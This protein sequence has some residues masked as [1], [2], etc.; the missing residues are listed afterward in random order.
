MDFEVYEDKT[1]EQNSSDYVINH[2]DYTSKLCLHLICHLCP[3]HREYIDVP[4]RTY[5]LVTQPIF[6]SQFFL[7]I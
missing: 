1:I 7:C 2:K 6:L 4:Y 3:I 5:K